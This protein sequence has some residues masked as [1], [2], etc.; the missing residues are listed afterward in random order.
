MR[1]AWGRRLFLP[2]FAIFIVDIFKNLINLENRE[3]GSVAFTVCI[4]K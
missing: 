4:Y 2:S 1:R 3:E